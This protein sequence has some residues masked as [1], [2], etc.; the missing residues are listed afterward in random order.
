MS[1]GRTSLKNSSKTPD[2]EAKPVQIQPVVP[3][4]A[5]EAQSKRRSRLHVTARQKQFVAGILVVSFA[6]VIFL[7]IQ[8]RDLPSLFSTNVTTDSAGEQS[9]GRT[10]SSPKNDDSAAPFLDSQ[11]D[12]AREKAEEIVNQF[13]SLQDT[14]ERNEYGSETHQDRY[15]AILDKANDGDI[16]FGQADYDAALNEFNSALEEMRQLLDDVHLD[17]DKW[18][19]EGVVAL[20]ERNTKA[21]QIAFQNAS[22]IKPLDLSAQTGLQRVALLPK[23]NELLRESDRAELRGRWDDALAYLSRV[24]DLDSLT[25]GVDQ[26]R[27]RINQA[28][29]DEA[30]NETLSLGHQALN[31]NDFDEAERL[32]NEVLQE[33][34]G[35]VAATTGLQQNSISRVAF[36]IEELRERARKEESSL[37]LEAALATYNEVLEIDSKLDFA[38][39]GKE[40]VFEILDVTEEMQVVLDDPGALSAD[41]ELRKAEQI[42]ERAEKLRGH[43]SDYDQSLDEFADLVDY[44]SQPVTVV[45]LSDNATEVTLSTQGKLGLFERHELRLRP[46][47]YQLVGSRD[48]RV[49]VR[50]TINVGRDM[51]PVRIVCE[52]QI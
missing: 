4:L 29:A 42:L 18:M 52:E 14:F 33:R 1:L 23:V 3:K 15:N 51:D 31:L 13:S 22:A 35:N 17:F 6:V 38:I 24:E 5:S 2:S 9:G 45:L 21:A 48:G 40:R 43:S 30:L 10:D 25:P 50:K 27:T 49:D 44:A 37:D 32:F 46:G 28:K 8:Q 34:P 36:R 7:W 12:R 16:L 19:E 20:D 47:R 26:R 41:K 39:Q 11:L